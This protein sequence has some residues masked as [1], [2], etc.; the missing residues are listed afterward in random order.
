MWI[1][2]ADMQGTFTYDKGGRPWESAPI[3][4]AL[5]L[6]ECE[7][8]TGWHDEAYYCGNELHWYEGDE[9]YPA[10]WLCDACHFHIWRDYYGFDSPEVKSVFEYLDAT[11]TLSEE[12]KRRLGDGEWEWRSTRAIQ[13]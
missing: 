8:V 13:D 3:P 12:I 11:P 2:A 9:K 7:N 10:A 4:E 1:G 5:H 6:Y